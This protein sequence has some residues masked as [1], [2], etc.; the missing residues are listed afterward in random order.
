MPGVR[1]RTN[2]LNSSFRPLAESRTFSLIPPRLLA[3]SSILFRFAHT[4]D[5][6][7]LHDAS[8]AG[9]RHGLPGPRFQRISFS[10]TR[11]GNCLPKPCWSG[12]DDTRRSRG[13]AQIGSLLLVHGAWSMYE[14]A[15][16]LAEATAADHEV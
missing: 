12:V 2:N 10:R 16:P 1:N 4:L 5:L 9:G 7:T 13:R 3:V 6:P 15:S 11:V 14:L 8:R